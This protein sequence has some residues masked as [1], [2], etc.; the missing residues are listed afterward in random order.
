[1]SR[2]V[3]V[4][5]LLGLLSAL[6]CGK[7]P[8]DASKDG[9]GGV[10]KKDAPPPGASPTQVIEDYLARVYSGKAT[11]TVVEE[12]KTSF[13]GKDALVV[14]AKFSAGGEEGSKI[15]LIQDEDGKG[16]KVVRQSDLESAKSFDE[17]MQALLK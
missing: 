16:P 11:V 12:K 17:N 15:F 1:M 7:K 6:G 13:R 2:L 5:C 8:T 14:S 9:D 10:Q 3:V 4:V